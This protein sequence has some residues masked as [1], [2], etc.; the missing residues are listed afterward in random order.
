MRGCA[1]HGRPVPSGVMRSLS[2]SRSAESCARMLPALL[3]SSKRRMVKHPVLPGSPSLFHVRRPVSSS[4]FSFTSLRVGRTSAE[5]PFRTDS[6]FSFPFGTLNCKVAVPSSLHTSM[7]SP[8]LEARLAPSSV[9]QKSGRATPRPVEKDIVGGG[10]AI[11]SS[12][13]NTI[14]DPAFPPTAFPFLFAAPPLTPTVETF[15][16]SV[17]AFSPSD[18]FLFPGLVG[19][20]VLLVLTF[21]FVVELR[22]WRFAG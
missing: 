20:F 11:H 7:S 17:E 22:L 3:A 15:G 1:F 4:C 6:I 10:L 14:D 12:Q 2:D 21:L 9:S 16:A 13:L 19:F 8:Q 18:N 5:R